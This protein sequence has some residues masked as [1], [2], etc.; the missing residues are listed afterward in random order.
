V[1][2]SLTIAITEI[3]A[4]DHK[5]ASRIQA[6]SAQIEELTLTLANLRRTAPAEAASAFQT[7]SDAQSKAWEK[8]FSEAEERTMREARESELDVAGLERIAEM[9]ETWERG[10][11]SLVTSKAGIG[12]TVA[13]LERARE[14][15]AYLDG[16]Q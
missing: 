10:L 14:V 15:V 1:G 13:R 12:G 5:L 8:R 16:T 9:Q 3:E 7:T 2:A 6:S 11:G 4:F